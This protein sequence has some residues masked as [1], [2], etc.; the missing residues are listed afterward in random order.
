[1]K[2]LSLV[3]L[4]LHFVAVMLLVGSL[5]AAIWFNFVGHRSNDA[6]RL[7]AS[8]ILAN[9]LPTTMTFL[10]NLGVPPLLFAQVLYGRALYTSSVLIA[11]SWISVI[12]LLILAYWL[13]YKMQDAI[14]NQKPAWWIG[15][16]SLLV[17]MG[18][19]RI[20]SLNMT[21]MLKPEVW[22]QM[23]AAN[24]Q[25]LGTPPI[26]P[27]ITP[28]W[29]FVMMGGFIVGGLWLMLLANMTH[30]ADGVRSALKKTGAIMPLIGAIPQIFFA[31]RTYSL[32]DPAVQNSLSTT[33]IHRIST[34]VYLAAVVVVAL[35]CLRQLT[36]GPSRGLA[37]TGIVFA[38]L[39]S[40]ATVVYRDG[41]RDYIL[42]SKGFN[43]WD[44]QEASNWSVI[45]LFLLLFVAMLG[46][47][48][49]LLSVVKRATPPEEQIAL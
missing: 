7:T 10:I 34:L 26:D 30:L 16:L 45:I 1:M 19:G 39:S 29:M 5:G 18:I 28:R 46:I 33:P 27:T 17:V 21:L 20:Y 41:M 8:Q 38:F 24:P 23:Y 11:V 9:R 42:S 49:W 13:I 48:G 2:A 43:V 40:V 14:R 35:L 4:S 36:A 6:D 12:F 31:Y 3:T 37:I 32:Q 44:R 25:G 15:L 47:V 22:P